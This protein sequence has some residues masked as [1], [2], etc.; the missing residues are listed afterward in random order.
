MSNKE[1]E[2]K[3]S[4]TSNNSDLDVIEE[5]VSNNIESINSNNKICQDSALRTSIS[6]MT[7]RILEK[8]EEARPNH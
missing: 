7:D 1:A 8:I 4:S 5:H 3:S 2:I 6:E